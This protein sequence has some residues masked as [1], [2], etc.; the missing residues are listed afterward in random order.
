MARTDVWRVCLKSRKADGQAWRVSAVF[1]LPPHP[2]TL[3]TQGSMP[4]AYTSL[5]SYLLVT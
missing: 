4:G 2:Y 1:L 5:F 3:S